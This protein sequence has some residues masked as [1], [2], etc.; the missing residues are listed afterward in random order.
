MSWSTRESGTWGSGG[1]H[2]DGV[3]GAVVGCAEDVRGGQDIHVGDAA[4]LKVPA[5][6]INKIED[7]LDGYDVAEG[8]QFPQDRGLVAGPGADLE[9][10]LVPAQGQRQGH[11]GDHGGLRDGL[12]VA[13]GQ[14]DVFVGAMAEFGRYE[15]FAWDGPH[16]VDNRVISHGRCKLGEQAVA[17]GFVD[18]GHQAGF[19]PGHGEARYPIV[20]E[21][22]KFVLR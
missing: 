8:Q 19:R 21:V 16:G 18:K 1:G 7:A 14:G 15:E 10:M 5:G 12:I 9:D 2:E 6:A 13:D 11:P 17:G 3:V 20:S 4:S 22:G